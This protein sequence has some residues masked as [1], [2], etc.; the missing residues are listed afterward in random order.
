MRRVAAPNI[1]GLPGDA[2]KV[3]I[4]SIPL[5]PIKRKSKPSYFWGT[6]YGTY[7]TGPNKK[8][9]AF[10]GGPPLYLYSR[11]ARYYGAI[12]RS[13]L[14]GAPILIATPQ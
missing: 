6:G 7:A 4:V 14:W 10:W 13:L 9:T 3:I 2:S 8:A 12:G 1:L 5:F 11:I